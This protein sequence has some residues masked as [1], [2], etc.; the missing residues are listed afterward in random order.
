MVCSAL[1]RICSRWVLLGL[2]PQLASAC[3]CAAPRPLRPSPSQ[4]IAHAPTTNTPGSTTVR[5][6]AAREPL[7]LLIRV[8]GLG[9]FRDENLEAA[10][11]VAAWARQRGLKV[12]DPDTAERIFATARAGKE[13]TRGEVCGTA[14]AD[15]EAKIRYQKELGTNG[16]L[17][18]SVGCTEASCSLRMWEFDD[19]GFDGDQVLSLSSPY[20]ANLPWRQALAQALGALPNVPIDA[21][22]DD[23]VGG[24]GLVGGISEER[25]VAHPE[26]LEWSVRT[27]RDWEPIEDSSERTSLRLDDGKKALRRCF[28]DQG[29][30]AELLVEVDRS[31]KVVRCESRNADSASAVCTCRAFVDH[32]HGSEALRSL[33]M[34]VGVHFAPA[35]VVTP[36]HAVVAVTSN[37]YLVEYRSRRGDP[38]WRPA[39]SDPSI[40][41]WDPPQTFSFARCFGQSK[42]SRDRAFRMKVEFD[43]KGS[44]VRSSVVAAAPDALSQSER[45]CI[46]QVMRSASA[47]CPAV[48]TSSAELAVQVTFQTI[49]SKRR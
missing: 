18:A 41:A 10:R 44:V 36:A 8:E 47:P 4:P 27:A 28:G 11:L 19:L 5:P 16:E 32:G 45:D 17:V 7:A 40:E 21:A 25:V 6:P 30:S 38:L 3:A 42:D 26:V 24:L 31:G 13:P 33:R 12:E 34:F 1:T 35:D 15:F 29:S 37:T 39:V 43:A 22:K 46:E 14:L 49:G 2:L 9:L 23:G 20:A 48:A